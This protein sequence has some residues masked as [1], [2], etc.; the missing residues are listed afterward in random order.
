MNCPLVNYLRFDQVVFCHNPVFKYLQGELY[1]PIKVDDCY[2]SI[3]MLTTP[4]GEFTNGIIFMA[5]D[6][7]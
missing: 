3:G 6:N 7:I 5:K 2:W 4:V 1:K